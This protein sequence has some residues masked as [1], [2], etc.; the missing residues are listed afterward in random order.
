MP[1]IDSND[2]A[3]SPENRLLMLAPSSAS[4]PLPLLTRDSMTAASAGLFETRSLPRSFSY[5]RKAGMFS[6]FPCRMPAC[7]IGVVQGVRAVHSRIVW[8][9][10]RTHRLTVGRF[11]EL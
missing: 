8:E 1:L 4:R 11:P 6:V 2:T 7:E 3:A 5:Q 9:P 10:D